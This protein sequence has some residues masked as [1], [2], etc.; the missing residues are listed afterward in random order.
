MENCGRRRNSRSHSPSR[1]RTL[2]A[3]VSQPRAPG[4]NFRQ[5]LFNMVFMAKLKRQFTEEA[6]LA[7]PLDHFCVNAPEELNRIVGKRILISFKQVKHFFHFLIA[8]S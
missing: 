5:H 4:S 1:T 2:P 8:F 6:L 7:H 3:P